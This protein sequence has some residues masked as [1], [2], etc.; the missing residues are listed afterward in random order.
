M[1]HCKLGDSIQPDCFSG[2]IW[3]RDNIDVFEL[4]IIVYL[5]L[6]LNKVLVR[7]GNLNADQ[8]FILCLGEEPGDS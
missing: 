5:S 4:K 2:D 8:P 3:N 1:I 6:K 7:R